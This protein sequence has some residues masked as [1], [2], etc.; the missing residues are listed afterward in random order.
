MA[1][2]PRPTKTI[3]VYQKDGTLHTLSTTISSISPLSSLPEEAQAL[4]KKPDVGDEDEAYVLTTPATIFHPQGGGQPSDTGHMVLEPATPTQQ[5]AQDQ[6]QDQEAQPATFHVRHVRHLPPSILHLGLFATPQPA[7]PLSLQNGAATQHVDRG[8][9]LLHS[10][11]HTAGHALGLAVMS[12]ATPSP[13]SSQPPLLPPSLRE[14]KASHAPGAASVEFEG[15]IPSAAKPAI[16]DAVDA[17]VARDLGVRI[18]FV[19]EEEARGRW[20]VGVKGDEGDGV[21]V[22]EIVGAGAYP[23]GGTHVERL[24]EVGRVVVRGVK[25]SKGVSRVSY[26]VVDV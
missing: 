9:R 15:L 2:T 20:G 3:A 18:L 13:T 21:R 16:Q 7:T 26:E 19:G 23:C 25:R 10:R 11:L 17:L 12:L 1:S 24:G 4:F 6:D 14:A 8:P 5:Q 22:V